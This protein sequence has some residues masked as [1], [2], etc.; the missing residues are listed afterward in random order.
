V[1]QTPIGPAIH[2]IRT[3][4]AASGAVRQPDAELLARFVGRRDEAAFTALVGRHGPLVWSVCRRLLPDSHDAEDAFQATFLTLARK[5]TSIRKPGA[6]GP[7]LYGVAARAAAQARTERARQSARTLPIPQPPADPLSELSARE[8][9]GLLDEELLRLP[10]RCRAPLV[11]CYL[12]GRTR[13]EAAQQLGWSLGTLK[14]RLERGRGL[15]RSRLARRGVVLSGAL[16]AA[17]LPQRAAALPP[18]L[19][20]ATVQSAMMPGIVSVR[21]MVWANNVGRGLSLS[22]LR[23]GAAL[24]LVMAAGLTLAGVTLLSRDRDETTQ[25][26]ALPTTPAS[27]DREPAARAD[28]QGEPLPAGAV[29]RVGSSRLRHGSY[30]ASLGYS[31]DGS[32]LI[33]SGARRIRVWDARSGKLLREVALPIRKV[34][35]DAVA[36]DGRNLLVLDGQT[37]RWFD[38]TTGNAIRE[39]AFTFPEAQHFA[40]FTPRGDA[41]AVIVAAQELVLYDLPSGRERFRWTTDK[42]WFGDLTLSADGKTLAA[43]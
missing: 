37:C 32:M 28:Q 26:A 10:E 43:L 15:L 9:S 8:L 35:D 25:P 1:A 22:R 31:A 41:L 18:G 42:V 39:L 34:P 30:L 5:A 4:A 16:L 14:R 13:D 36:F 20:S 33:S 27:A 11:L 23:L 2:H 6:L 24:T 21:A 3:L 17:L 29:A 12:E 19:F 40:H 38:L 7:W